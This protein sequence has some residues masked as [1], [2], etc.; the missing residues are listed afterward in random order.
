MDMKPAEYFIGLTKSESLNLIAHMPVLT[1]QEYF[2]LLNEAEKRPES[3][4]PI[5]RRTVEEGYPTS[6]T[7]YKSRM[8]QLKEYLKMNPLVTRADIVEAFGLKRNGTVDHLI[9]QAK[10]QGF[11]EKVGYYNYRYTGE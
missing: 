2:L 6:Y 10:K 5:N 3:R 1:K 8:Q 11:I 9:A 4:Y 7:S